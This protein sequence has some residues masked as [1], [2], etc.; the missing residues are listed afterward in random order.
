M[1]LI[2]AKS[3]VRFIGEDSWEHVTMPV[4]AD[5]FGGVRGQPILFG[6]YTSLVRDKGVTA[7]LL[8]NC[9]LTNRLD[10][11]LRVKNTH[12][13][14]HNYQELMASGSSVVGRTCLL[15]V[16]GVEPVPLLDDDHCASCCAPGYVRNAN[17]ALVLAPDCESCLKPL[18]KLCCVL[19]ADRSGYLCASCATDRRCG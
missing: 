12:R 15:P 16:C 19:N 9:F 10:E 3:L 1:P 8:H 6:A 13:P 7:G 2:T 18:C 17:G 4:F 14:D 5:Y 11:L